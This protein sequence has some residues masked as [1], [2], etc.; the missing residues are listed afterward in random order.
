MRVHHLFSTFVLVVGVAACGGGGGGGSSSSAPAGPGGGTAATG[1]NVL[2]LKVE[3]GPASNINVPF[4]SVTVCAPGSTSACQTIDHVLLDTGSTGLRLINS[5][6]NAG[7]VLPK[8]T[9]G[10]GNNVAE[11][12]VFADGYSWGSVR[13]ADVTMGGKTASAIPIQIIA[14]PAFPT[15]PAACSSYGPVAENT[16]A[17]FGANGVL[18]LASFLQDCGDYCAR[19]ASDAAYYVCPSGICSPTTLSVARQLQN[20]AGALA[21]ENNGIIVELPA[22]PPTGAATVTGTLT[23]GIGTQSN[24]AVGSVTIFDLDTSGDAKTSFNGQTLRA[25]FDTGSNGLFFPD[26]TIPLCGSSTNAPGFFCP[27]ATLNFVATVLGA[28][29]GSSKGVNFSIANA[30]LLVSGSSTFTAFNNIGAPADWAPVF[31]WGL[32]FFFGRRVVIAFE[33]QPTPAGAGPYVG[34]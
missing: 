18:G 11:C 32:P 10:S 23:I 4:V 12:V 24:N 21:T 30:G 3:A 15:V 14:D 1:Q 13:L 31:D 16:V 29:N 6:L 34:F 22:V 9:D 2:T 27:A 19:T 26:S 25:F 28:S 5:V 20:P 17:S 8:Q 33:Q 7:I